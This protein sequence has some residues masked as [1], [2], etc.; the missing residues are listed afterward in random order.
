MADRQND[1]KKE[2]RK[3]SIMYL[4]VST[5]YDVPIACCAIFIYLSAFIV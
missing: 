3:N 2:K 5:V 4:N 1:N